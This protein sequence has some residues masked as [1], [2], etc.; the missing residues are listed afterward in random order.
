MLVAG[1]RV[2]RQDEATERLLSLAEKSPDHDTVR[3]YATGSLSR[4]DFG[5][6]WDA[7]RPAGRLLVADLVR[8]TADRTFR[9]E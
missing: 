8:L 4:S 2:E 9:R 1:S 5:L 6:D 7:L 3:V